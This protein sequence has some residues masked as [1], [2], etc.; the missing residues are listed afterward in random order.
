MVFVN[1]FLF[2]TA[3]FFI[4]ASLSGHGKVITYKKNLDLFKNYLRK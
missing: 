4:S 2:V 1:L 3:F